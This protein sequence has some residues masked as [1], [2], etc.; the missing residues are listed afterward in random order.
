MGEVTAIDP[1]PEAPGARLEVAA[2]DAVHPV[3]GVAPTLNVEAAQ[4]QLS[5]F[6][7]VTT[8]GTAVP[9]VV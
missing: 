9:A 3:G 5:L 7:T 8:Y 2:D 1:D 6:V 4:A